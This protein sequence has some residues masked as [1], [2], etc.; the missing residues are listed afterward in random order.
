M[1]GL[2]KNDY[3]GNTSA[4]SSGFLLVI[5]LTFL[6]WLYFSYSAGH[7]VDMPKEMITVLGIAFFGKGGQKGFE[8]IANGK[9]TVTDMEPK[10]QSLFRTVTY[11][12]RSFADMSKK[13]K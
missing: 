11:L 1:K 13:G 9:M 2:L 5:V 3:T 7:I 10:I 12:R 4:M 8:A 6:P